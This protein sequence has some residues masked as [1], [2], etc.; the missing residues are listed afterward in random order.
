M[1]KHTPGVVG[2]RRFLACGVACVAAIPLGGLV[3]NGVQAAD[4]PKLDEA[5]PQA[6]S[7]G[8]RHDASTVDVAAF[9]KRAG[10]EGAKQLCSNCQLYTGAAD[11]EWGPCSIFPG[12][13]VAANG[14]CNAWVPKA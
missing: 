5:D 6:A 3:A 11:S 1:K 13:L 2:R 4:M 10:D 14:W 7:L 9:P 12:K 8:Y